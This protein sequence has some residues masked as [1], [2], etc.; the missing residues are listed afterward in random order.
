[1]YDK[2]W[3]AFVNIQALEGAKFNDLIEIDSD[4]QSEEYIG[5][6]CNVLIVNDKINEVPD[7]I[8]AGLS[9]LYMKVK[10]IDKIQNLASLIEYDEIGEGVIKEAEWLLKTKYIFK[11][12]DK[13][14]PYSK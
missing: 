13:L 6:W 2:V 12:S 3:I 11:I 5:A 1:M 4:K 10:F 9:E 14:F 8:E 7:I